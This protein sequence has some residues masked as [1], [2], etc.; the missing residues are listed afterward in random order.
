MAGTIA[1][2][3]AATAILTSLSRSTTRAHT[4]PSYLSLLQPPTTSLNANIT[5]SVGPTLLFSSGQWV[6]VSWTG[7][8]SWMYPDAFI[9][10]F[11]P[12]NALDDPSLVADVAPIK[13]Q[14]LTAQKPFPGGHRLG[15]ELDGGKG[16]QQQQGSGAEVVDAAA[17][18]TLRFRLLNLRDAEGYR[19]GMFKGGVEKPVLVAKTAEAVTFARPYEVFNGFVI[20]WGGGV[21]FLYSCILVF[22]YFVFLFFGI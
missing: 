19:F 18:E 17:V 14:F 10:A 13:Y 21:V 16:R 1:R 20:F 3:L 11:S 22:L 6:T 5:L 7:I 15:D 4:E 12:G 2:A 8:E 9:A